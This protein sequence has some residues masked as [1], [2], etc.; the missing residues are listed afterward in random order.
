MSNII[1]IFICLVSG[2]LLTKYKV[3]PPDG[4]KTLNNLVIYICMPALGVLYIPQIKVSSELAFPVSV[5][6]IVFLSSLLFFL[7]LKKLLKLDKK[8]TGALILTGGLSNTAFIGFPV[9]LVLLG[10][11]GLKT[12][13]VIDQAG[14]FFVLATGGVITGSVASKG[15]FSVKKIFKDI[16]IFPPFIG[17]IAGAIINISGFNLPDII[18]N[19]LRSLGSVLIVLALVSVGMQLKIKGLDNHIKNL[20]IGLSY[21]L[22]IAPL[23]IF[24]LFYLVFKGRGVI[25]D[26]CLIESAMSPM[27]MGAIMADNYGLNPNLANAMVSIGIPLSFLTISFWYYITTLF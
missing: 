14:S 15:N 1:L 8:T 10:E 3:L 7:L 26:A 6:W 24:V 9:L 12:G 19:I 20:F 4:Y 11:E 21:K 17:F 5:M 25:V 2:K 23:I 18:N 22:L 27:I 13:I 16:I